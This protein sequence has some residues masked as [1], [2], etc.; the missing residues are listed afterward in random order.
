MENKK[1]EIKVQT[2]GE[3]VDQKYGKIVLSYLH[4]L[5]NNEYP[6]GVIFEDPEHHAWSL[7]YFEKKVYQVGG[8]FD[9]DLIEST[10]FRA[11]FQICIEFNENH[12]P[13]HFLCHHLDR[14]LEGTCGLSMAELN[15][16]KNNLR[17]SVQA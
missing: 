17:S 1:K 14:N 12:Q 2:E 15:L 8:G 16:M 7:G 5:R 6:D 11:V 9:T 4:L 10:S 3:R 13:S